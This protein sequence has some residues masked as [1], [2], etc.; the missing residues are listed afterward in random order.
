MDKVAQG[1]KFRVL[2]EY[3]VVGICMVAFAITAIGLLG[4]I[5]GKSAA[6]KRDFLSYWAAGQ[7]LAHRADPYNRNEIVDLERSAGYAS[8]IPALIMRNPPWSLAMVLP[9]GFLG[10]RVAVLLWLAILL[11]CLVASVQMVRVMHRDST[12]Q[13][14]LFGY[15]FGPAI[16]CLFAG[17]ISL[18]ILLGLVLFLR[19]HPSRPFLAGVSL[20]LCMLK[21]HLFVPF[22]IVLLAWVFAVRGYKILAGVAVSLGFSTA[23]AFI[24]NPHIWVQYAQMIHSEHVEITP[25]PCLSIALRRS[26]S[27]NSIWLQYV[28]L[29]IGCVWALAYFRRHRE[30]WDWM[31]HGSPLMLVSVL[32]APYAWISDQ[33]ILIPALL[34]GVYLTRS[35]SLLAALALASAV[36]ELMMFRGAQPFHSR[37]YIWTAP[38]WLVW[39]FYAVRTGDQRCNSVPLAEISSATADSC[40][41]SA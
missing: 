26:I 16:I 14:Q 29:V 3:L 33:A 5:F 32:V 4:T 34:H 28:P 35:R 18:L 13:M 20:W 6:S 36:I 41:A 2:A 7:Q 23:I 38:V 8:N 30:H 24:L 37:L 25:I 15:S 27:P 21:P 19:L 39:Y 11:A 22:G 17:Q 9:F 1:R 40:K 10:A 31:V 12:N